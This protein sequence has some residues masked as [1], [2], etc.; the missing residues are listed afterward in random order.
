MTRPRATERLRLTVDA[1]EG[2]TF[3]WTPDDAPAP[4]HDAEVRPLRGDAADRAVGRHRYEVTVDGW[5]FTVGVESAARAALRERASR[6]SAQQDQG[7]STVVKAQIPGRVTR[8]W[9][10]EGDTV[11]AGQRLLAI[12]A[13]KMENEVRS[14][15]AGT[16]GAIKVV[17][18]DSVELADELLTVS[19]Q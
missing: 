12:E 17:A 19:G 7:G 18:G 11:E 14:P 10:A 1:V 2:A 16:V 3:D 9:V 13:M 15:Q 5:V 6:G 8:L 4:V